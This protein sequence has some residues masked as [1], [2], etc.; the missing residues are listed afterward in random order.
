MAGAIVSFIFLVSSQIKLL[1][2]APCKS[3][4]DFK[5]TAYDYLIVSKY[6]DA[7][8][9]SY[10]TLI[11]QDANGNRFKNLDLHFD[12]SGLFNFIK[13]GDSIKKDKGSDLVT[14][15]NSKIDTT[16]EVDFGCDDK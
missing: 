4:K 1:N 3:F 15:V 10:P 2:D 5:S 11:I 8:E 9:H 16:L 6:I 12:Q 7:N 13:I 14:I